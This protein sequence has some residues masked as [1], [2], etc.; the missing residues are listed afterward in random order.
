MRKN[1]RSMKE[2][3]LKRVQEGQNRKEGTAKG[4]FKTDLEDVPFWNCADGDHLLDIIP[5]MAGPY[6]PVTPEGKETYVLEVFVHRGVG[7]TEGSIICLAETYRKPCPICEDRKKK[8]IEGEEHRIRLSHINRRHAECQAHREIQ[9][10]G[11][12]LRDEAH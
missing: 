10:C 3:L 8:Q 2:A 1:R 6:D 7:I 5:Y 9:E 12:N 4:I 11:S